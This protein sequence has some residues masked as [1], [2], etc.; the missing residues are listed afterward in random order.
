MPTVPIE[1]G[2]YSSDVDDSLLMC[3]CSAGG[4]LFDV[5]QQHT[6]DRKLA[7]ETRT[8]TPAVIPAVA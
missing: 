7:M 3:T 1:I 8:I 5:I 6:T 4:F 2:I